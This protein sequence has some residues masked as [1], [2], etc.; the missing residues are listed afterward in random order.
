A[1]RSWHY[2]YDRNGNMVSQTVPGAT[3][4]LSDASFRTPPAHD[5]LDRPTPKLIGQRD[6][7][8]ADPALLAAGTG[9]LPWA[10]RANHLG[11]LRR[12]QT[13]APGVTQPALAIDL[14]HNA[15]GQRTRTAHALGIAGYEELT[16][17][18]A[19]DY[20]VSGAIRTTRYH[21]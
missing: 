9:L 10:E 13:F 17:Q 16:R 15:Q 12:W 20:Y 21:D 4:A 18:L 5:D 19:R 14:D 3:D 7:P 8:I 11:R 1:G 2:G 6:L